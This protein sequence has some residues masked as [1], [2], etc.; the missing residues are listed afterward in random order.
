MKSDIAADTRRIQAVCFDWGG[1]LMSEVGP[2]DQPM[3][4]WP[5]VTAMPGAQQCLEA[6]HSRFPLAI[7]TNATVSR[8]P[9]IE[10]ALDRV[11]F[12][13][14]FRDIF[15][16]TELGFRKD[17]AEFWRAVQAALNVPLKSIA[18]SELCCQSPSPRFGPSDV[19]A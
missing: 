11:G 8:R 10:L 9:M 6:L 1:T 16:F 19:F 17:Q 4:L 5:H 7:A 2:Q 18:M 15:C 14:Y 3:A 13:S 12:R